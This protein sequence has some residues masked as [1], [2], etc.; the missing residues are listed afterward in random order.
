MRKATIRFVISVCL[1]GRTRLVI[2]GFSWKLI[3][4][5]FSNIPCYL[6]PFD[7]YILMSSIFSNNLSLRS[8]FNVKG[9]AL[10]PYQAEGKNYSSIYIEFYYFFC[11]YKMRVNMSAPYVSKHFLTAIH[12]KFVFDEIFVFFGTVTINLHFS[13]L[14][15]DSFPNFLF[16][17][18][19]CAALEISFLHIFSV[20]V[21]T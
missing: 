19:L 15:K 20:R 8:S 7:R 6:V 17:C 16:N 3:F 13:T 9:K 10:Y 1:L 2:I 14:S 21:T 5:N 18:L 4:E 12:S 11:E